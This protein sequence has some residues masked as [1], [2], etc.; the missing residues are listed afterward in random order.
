MSFKK[1]IVILIAAFLMPLNVLALSNNYQDKVS[2]IT[3]TKT[4]SGKINL[5]FFRGE[6]CPHCKEEEKW[7]ETIKEK[8]KDSL[9]IYDFEVW[10]N[11]TNAKY[12]DQVKKEFNY[13]SQGVPFTVIGDSYFVGYSTTSASSMENK[14][15]SYLNQTDTKNNVKI[16]ILG[17]INMQKV[18]I[19]LVAIILGFIDGFNPCAMWVLLFLISMLFKMEDKHKRWILGFTFLITSALIYFLSMLGINLVLSVA[20][21]SYLKIIIAIFILGAG[22]VNLRKY[23]KIRKD[24]A[25]CTVVDS[26]KRKKLISRMKNIISSKSFMLSILGIIALGA[27]INLIELACS[28]GF[29]VIFTE[30]LALNKVN[31]ITKILYLLLYI[32]FY[33]IDDLVVFIISMTSLE[34]TGITNKYNKLCT[35]VSSI[36]MIIMGLL[37]IIKPEWLMLNF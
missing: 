32:F 26:S 20:T 30:I 8:Y 28:L 29:P 33:M 31:G 17:N 9:N 35:L 7:L 24:E 13:T 27:S 3:N 22:L 25:G 16:P 6:G 23:L 4:E 1:I 15:D 14:I 37:L 11:K 34:A 2:K 18:S 19:P 10:Q 21:I 36:I 12:L 5:Y